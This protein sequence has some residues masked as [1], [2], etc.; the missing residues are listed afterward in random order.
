MD[1]TRI[2]N[3]RIDLKTKAKSKSTPITIS[4]CHFEAAPLSPDVA[5]A[6]RA[7]AE[8][9]ALN[10]KALYEAAV[11]LQGHSGPLLTINQ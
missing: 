10:A 1:G 6:V 8:A 3:W 5:A 7:I 2:F 9:C 4:N 11:R